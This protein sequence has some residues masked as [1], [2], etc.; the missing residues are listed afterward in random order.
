[1][2]LC[3]VGN[4]SFHF[5]DQKSEYRVSIDEF[6]A[7]DIKEKVYYINVNESQ[8]ICLQKLPNWINLKEFVNYSNYYESMG[9]DRIM[10][11]EAI[12]SG[13]VVDAGSAITVDKVKNS[14]FEGGFIYPGLKILE[15]TYKELSPRL[16]TSFNF[17][18]DLDKMPNNTQDAISY[19]VLRTLYNEVMRH[20]SQ[21]YLTGGDAQKLK[22]IFKDSILDELLIFKGMKNIMKK[23]QLC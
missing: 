3:D 8:E 19:G 21:I 5:Y 11:C 6:N 22:T 9:I 13:I 18:L 16:E 14:S 2:T 7:T 12:E 1:M 17:E 23:A 20:N 10:A 15:K 4:T